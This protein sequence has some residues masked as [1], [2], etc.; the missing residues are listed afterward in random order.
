MDSASFFSDFCARGGAMTVASTQ[1]TDALTLAAM[2]IAIAAV[3]AG[4]PVFF[5]GEG[6]PTRPHG[7]PQV[8]APTPPAGGADTDGRTGTVR[9]LFDRTDSPVDH[10]GKLRLVEDLLGIASVVNPRP[11]IIIKDANYVL[12]LDGMRERV[13]ALFAGAANS[14]LSIAVSFSAIAGQRFPIAGILQRERPDASRWIDH[15]T[16]LWLGPD[17]DVADTTMVNEYYGLGDVRT[18]ATDLHRPVTLARRV[19]PHHPT[20]WHVWLDDTLLPW[21]LERIGAAADQAVAAE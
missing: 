19:A 13:A 9:V 20:G 4:R 6:Q 21:R 5:I 1:R 11:V 15:A 3:R 12:D 17:L 16:H 8:A 2:P 18:A 7:L 14:G 10:A